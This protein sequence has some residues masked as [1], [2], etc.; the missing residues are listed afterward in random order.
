MDAA[1]RMPA[2][3]YDVRA[4]YEI[5]DHCRAAMRTH[6]PQVE[7]YRKGKSA[8]GFFMGAVMRRGRGTLNPVETQTR[9]KSLLD[10]PAEPRTHAEVIA[11]R[12]HET[13]RL[14]VADGPV[15]PWKDAPEAYRTPLVAAMQDLLRRGVIAV[16]VPQ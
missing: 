6:T 1:E 12:F 5:E 2:D 14:R 3:A 9:L 15:L 13:H 7:L 11:M 4:R 16:P 8:L 10:D